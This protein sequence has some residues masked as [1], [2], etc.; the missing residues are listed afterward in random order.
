MA[1]DGTILIFARLKE[2]LAK[3]KPW[4]IALELAFGRAWDSIR[5]ANVTTLITA[6]ILY[7]P[8]N[9]SFIPVSG[10]VRGFAFTLTVGVLV[11]LFTGIVVTRNLIRVFYKSKMAIAAK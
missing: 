9:W 6:F 7:N 8:L 2:E 11:S 10:V 5:D 4:Q 1:V 3:G